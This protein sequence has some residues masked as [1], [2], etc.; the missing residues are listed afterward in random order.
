M[1]N[2]NPRKTGIIKRI[3]NG[4]S[5]DSC[6]EIDG[7]TLL[8]ILTQRLTYP[9]VGYAYHAFHAPAE[10]IMC[11]LVKANAVDAADPNRNMPLLEIRESK[12]R[13]EKIYYQTRFDCLDEAIKTICE[14]SGLGVQIILDAERKKFIFEVLEGIDRSANQAERPPMIFNKE[15]DNVTNR[16]YVSD[17]SEYKNTAVTAGQ[18]E[19]ADRKIVTVGD[20]YS[21]MDRYEM[22]VDAR[23]I[24]D[25]TLLPDR[26][27]AQLAEY[28]CQDSYSSEVDSSKY[29]TKWDLGDIVLTI[30]SEYGVYMNERI[31]EIAET[32]DENG[33]SMLPTFGTIQKTIIEKV[34]SIGS[35]EPLVEGIKGE[36]GEQGEAGEQG[37]QGYSL[38]YNW[39]GTKLGVKRED[40]SSFAYKDLQGQKG[41]TGS[42][43]PKGEKG[44]T[45]AQGPK[46]D[47]GA[48]GPA[49]A[50]GTKIYVQASAPTGVA[51]GTVWIDT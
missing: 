1:L 7:F 35:N 11:T 20:E 46:G 29:G 6:A 19:G 12:G 43:G 3:Q 16:M 48:T 42:Q 26:G 27:K 44:D 9:P 45:G 39:D 15:Y 49:G 10:D 36:Q 50:D 30:D 34:Q 37:P 18:G 2:N 23:D 25:E 24:E 31:V 5:D 21:G 22:F 32:F 41:E 4:D 40:E 14:A 8:H 13:G 47:T 28:T 17:M 38:Q 33:Y 51:A